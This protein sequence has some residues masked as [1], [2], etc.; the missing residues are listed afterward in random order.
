MQASLPPPLLYLYC[1]FVFAVSK[2]KAFSLS[3]AAAARTTKAAA[4]TSKAMQQNKCSTTGSNLAL[5]RFIV[6]PAL[7]LQL[8]NCISYLQDGRLS[9]RALIRSGGGGGGHGGPR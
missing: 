1:H 9:A 8:I 2:G 6:L 5:V 3:H 4:V 7:M